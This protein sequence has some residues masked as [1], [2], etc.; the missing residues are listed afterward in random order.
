MEWAWNREHLLRRAGRDQGC[1]FNGGET[2][3]EG[4][5]RHGAGSGG[6]GK[7]HKLRETRSALCIAK[8]RAGDVF[9]GLKRQTVCRKVLDQTPRVR[10]G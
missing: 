2:G 6:R 1:T 4:V 9:A 5:Q 3:V 10:G 7:N 8:H